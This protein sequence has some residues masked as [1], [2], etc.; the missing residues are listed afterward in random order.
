[1]LVFKLNRLLS[2]NHRRY[3]TQRQ[4]IVD[5]MKKDARPPWNGTAISSE[6]FKPPT[7]DL[8][9][10]LSEWLNV[11]YRRKRMFS[12]LLPKVSARSITLYLNKMYRR[13]K[14]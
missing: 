5:G 10:K 2:I 13:L 6:I 9:G 1:M 7:Y 8:G 4:D 14:T 11:W 12:A 3:T